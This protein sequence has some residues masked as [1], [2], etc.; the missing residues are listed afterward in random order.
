MDWFLSYPLK[1]RPIFRQTLTLTARL[2]NQKCAKVTVSG[3][4]VNYRSFFIRITVSSQR[5]DVISVQVENPTSV[6]GTMEVFII[7]WWLNHRH[8]FV[9][10]SD[11]DSSIVAE[12]KL[13]VDIVPSG[14]RH[15]QFSVLILHAASKVAVGSADRPVLDH[16]EAR[17][18]QAHVI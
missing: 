14:G 2:L 16:Y 13:S 18:K 9:V 3:S 15:R 11:K 12:V 10:N 4:H 8:D 6:H 1:T 5:D 7:Y 17:Y